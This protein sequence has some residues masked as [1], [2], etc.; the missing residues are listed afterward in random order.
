MHQP[1]RPRSEEF[2]EELENTISKVLNK[3]ILI[4]RGD[5]GAKV[6]PDTYENWAGTVGQY[7]TGTTNDRGLCLLEFVS[8]QRLIIANT[9][10]PHKLSRRTTL[11]VPN[12]QTHNQTDFILTPK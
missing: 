9:L 2:Y 7:G 12:G 10:Y 4:I 8:N 11:H 1:Q 6:G 3:D 5:F